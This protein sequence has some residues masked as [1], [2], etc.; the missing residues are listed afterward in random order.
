MNGFDLSQVSFDGSTSP[1]KQ[2][3]EIMQR[4]GAAPGPS[5]AG[6]LGLSSQDMQVFDPN[7]AK[8][9]FD[10]AS[11]EDIK[12]M[13]GNR[14]KIRNKAA[15]K[16][17][18]NKD[19]VEMFA[20]RTRLATISSEVSGVKDTFSK[21]GIAERE[22]KF[23]EDNLK[24]PVTNDDIIEVSDKEPRRTPPKERPAKAVK[25][26]DSPKSVPEESNDNTALLLKL[27]K[28]LDELKKKP[29]EKKKITSKEVILITDGTTE[30]TEVMIDG[31]ELP[32]EKVTFIVDKSTGEV[33]CSAKIKIT[34]EVKLV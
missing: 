2:L 30:G 29:E 13:Q 14:D 16:V 3:S 12:R 25:D 15:E 6:K 19:S 21:N 27:Q 9:N 23:L 7:D 33:I 1:E 18:L 4:A 11:K 24:S 20:D 22:K 28:Q 5:E 34:K 26:F 10:G 32:F 8:P 17:L 31:K